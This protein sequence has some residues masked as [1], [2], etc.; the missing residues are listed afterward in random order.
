MNKYR[1]LIIF[2]GAAGP[3]FRVYDPR[4]SEPLVAINLKSNELLKLSVEMLSIYRRLENRKEMEAE[5]C[6]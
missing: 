5:T 2:D 1:R 4:N 6:D 3:E